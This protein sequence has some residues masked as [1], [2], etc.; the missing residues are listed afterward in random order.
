M[1]IY[2]HMSMYIYAYNKKERLGNAA[3]S[4]EQLVDPRTQVHELSPSPPQTSQ[5]IQEH[6]SSSW[7]LV[8]ETVQRHQNKRERQS[9]RK[10]KKT[11][12]CCSILKTG[13]SIDLR[14]ELYS[15]SLA[16][17]SKTNNRL[18][19]AAASGGQTHQQ[20]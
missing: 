12:K 16:L 3:T 14:T 18:G 19:N 13:Y 11:C 1:Y 5:Q 4:R 17:S 9:E 6:A 8:R 15:L 10:S 2:I 20:I 7:T